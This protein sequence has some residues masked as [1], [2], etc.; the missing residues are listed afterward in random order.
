MAGAHDIAVNRVRLTP[1]FI[2]GLKP[3]TEARGRRVVHDNT[4][5]ALALRVTENG[6][7]SFILAGRFPSS[8]N[9]TRR[10]LGYADGP[11]AL[12]LS[13]AEDY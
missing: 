8:R 4:V 6:H 5:P 3:N 7:K 10:F 9:Q 11:R 12:S 13:E 1:L 2:K